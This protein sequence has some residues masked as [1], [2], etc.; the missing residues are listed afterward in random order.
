LL[1]SSLLVVI[2][3]IAIEAPIYFTGVYYFKSSD[4]FFFSFWIWAISS[5][6]SPIVCFKF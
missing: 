6:L 4:S 1:T 5:S 2:P 3:I